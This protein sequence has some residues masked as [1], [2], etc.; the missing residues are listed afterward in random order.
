MKLYEITLRGLSMPR[1]YVVAADPTEAEVILSKDLKQK[2]WG[3]DEDREIKTIEL[4]AEQAD[5][6]RCKH[7]LLITKV[8]GE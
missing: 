6:P 7:R 3:F 5:Y 2:D 1:F 4:L 8:M